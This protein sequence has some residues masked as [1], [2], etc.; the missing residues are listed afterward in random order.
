MQKSPP[1]TDE[2]DS[3]LRRLA[4]KGYSMTRLHIRFKR[5][6]G[7]IVGRA[8]ALG[9]TIKKPARLPPEE[10]VGSNGSLARQ[11]GP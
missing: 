6:R 9:M 5:S 11:S 2:Y 7:F 4:E 3:E 10:R 1:W 8:R